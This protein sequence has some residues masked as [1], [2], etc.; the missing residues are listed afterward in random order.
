[1]TRRDPT[2]RVGAATRVK[3]GLDR[4][5]RAV[6]GLF[7]GRGH[8]VVA[9]LDLQG[10]DG[11]PDGAAVLRRLQRLV[12][13]SHLRAAADLLEVEPCAVAIVG[14]VNA[15]KSTLLNALAGKRLARVSA[16]PGTTVVPERHDALGFTLIDTPGGDE[17]AG[18][19]RRRLALGAVDEAGISVFL[20]DAT[21][22]VTTSDRAVFDRVVERMLDRAKA[23]AAAAWPGAAPPTTVAGLLKARRLIVGANKLDA[24]ARAERDAVIRRIADDAG[25]A[26]HDVLG[27]SARRRS[28]L[29]VLARRMVDGAPAM[30]D[31]L[32]LVMP[33]FADQLASQ[34]VLRYATTAATVALAPIPFSHVIPL[35]ALQ[36]AL[37]VRLARLYGHEL[38]WRRSREVVPALAAGVGWRELFRQVARLVPVA[39][40]ALNAS[41]AFVGTYA[42]GRAAQHLLRTGANPTREELE[43]WRR[44]GD[45]ELE[46][47]GIFD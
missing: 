41:V 20:F 8:E 21:R 16:T 5:V 37:V 34:L 23:G 46:E 18:E 26:A 11:V 19:E 31:A 33:A 3:R 29:D 6:T 14:P 28:G 4:T 43:T 32:A 9:A 30:A 25:I 38:S 13:V 45:A 1:M 40:R 36:L 22:G 2:R 39:G 42:T 35:T 17:V 10:L 44:E 15:G 7:P 47:A 27:I 24:V 12:S